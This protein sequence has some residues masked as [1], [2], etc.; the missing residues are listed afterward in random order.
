MSRARHRRGAAVFGLLCAYLLVWSVA[1]IVQRLTSNAAVIKPLNAVEDAAAFLLPAG[2]LHIALALSVE[3]RRSRF[4]EVV[5]WITYVVCL[6]MAAGAVFF[7]DQQF[8][9]RPPHF[10]IGGIPGEVFGWGWIAARIVIFGVAIWWIGSALRR[11]AGDSSVRRGLLAALATVAVGA[12]GGVMRI[13]PG[14]ADTA[15][16]IGVSLVA[17]GMVMAAY[18][19]FAAGIF[20]AQGAAERAFRYSLFGGLII[21]AYVA[22]LIGSEVLT[23]NLLGIELPVVTALA[24]VVS[25]TLFEPISERFIGWLGGTEGDAASDRVLRALGRDILTAQRPERAI[26][27]S[28]ARLSRTFGLR[29]ASV[30]DR[31]GAT[32]AETGQPPDAGSAASLRMSLEADGLD[33]GAVLFGPKRSGLPLSPREID[34]LRVAA[35][36][37]AASLRFGVRHETQAAALSELRVE[38]AAVESRGSQ[39]SQALVDAGDRSGEGLHLF[40]LG[41]LR[42]ERGGAAVRQWGGPKAGARQAEALFAFLYDRGE[43]GVSKDEIIELIWPDTDLD[44][45]D[46]AFHRT[47][48][49]LRSTLEPSRRGRRRGASVEFVNDRYR[50][51]PLVVE[52]SDVR[53][54]EEALGAASQAAGQADAV[55]QFERARYLY[56]GDYLD[57]CPFYGDSSFVVDRRE[58]L[59]GRMIDLL[60]ALGERY[61]QR[62]DRPAAAGCFRQAISVAGEELP[63]AASALTRLD[64]PA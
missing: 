26:G 6:G 42:A 10:A 34:L 45:A 39:L 40:A 15:P 46:L 5:L 31:D 35:G 16:W 59:R 57:D 58:L 51:S 22:L 21:T 47:L 54:F 63:S 60:L 44:H 55:A 19:V 41:P 23:Q 52:W 25:V 36:Y 27:P 8:S 37:L 28:L 14:V 50:L 49:G 9:V 29:G 17:A 64:S 32:I 3:G 2:T 62:G 24:I 48:G 53:A 7:P 61:A 38:L 18:A 43:R 56:R 12:I 33:Y 20:L 11:A 1:I 4:Q 30:H 13:L